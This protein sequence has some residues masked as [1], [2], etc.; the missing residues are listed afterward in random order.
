MRVLSV[1]QIGDIHFPQAKLARIGDFGDQALSRN[2][3]QILE[4]PKLQIVFRALGRVKSNIETCGFL[5]CGDLTTKGNLEEYKL[6]IQY[7]VDNM[8][9]DDIAAVPRS[10]WHVV[11]GNHDVARKSLEPNSNPFPALFR[12]L[13]NE[14]NS[15]V[16]SDVLTVEGMRSSRIEG[17]GCSIALFSLNSCIGCGEWRRIPQNLQTCIA[18]SLASTLPAAHSDVERF[19]AIAEQL[20]APAFHP[21]HVED[22]CEA[23]K[24]LDQRTMPFI[25]AHHNLLPQTVVRTE[26][27]TELVNSGMVRSRF[28]KLNRPVVYCHGHI[29]DDTVET[30]TGYGHNS[31]LIVSVSAPQ[32]TD[33]FNVLTVWFGK[34][35]QPLGLEVHKH[36]IRQDGDVSPDHPIRISFWPRSLLSSRPD[37]EVLSAVA[38]SRDGFEPVIALRERFDEASR[39][40]FRT[41]KDWLIEAE[42][43][44]LVE[45]ENR[46]SANARDLRVRKVMP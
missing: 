43:Y 19:D 10:H 3:R 40:Q 20:D 18:E 44:G 7:L 21:E 25:L 32:I 22:T 9:L 26:V 46:E 35:Q 41:L 33:G 17:G 34:Q 14:W 42:W 13:E 15:L 36:R 27:Y 12:P 39:P 11:P 23:I 16:P 8:Q 5:I 30:I 45:L 1:I 2:F 31:G 6:C 24:L 4:Q 29:H 28:T 38:H 37:N